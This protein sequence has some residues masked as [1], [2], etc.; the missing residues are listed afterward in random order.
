M[1][2]NVFMIP[3]ALTVRAVM[4]KDRFDEFVKSSEIRVR[5]TIKKDEDIAILINRAGY[6]FEE[7]FGLKKTHFTG[8]FFFW[9]IQKGVWEAVFSKYYAQEEIEK[10]KCRLKEVA[11]DGI[12]EREIGDVHTQSSEIE[13]K[14]LIYPTSF[15]DRSILM[16]T[17]T[18][19][20]IPYN[21]QGE[22]IIILSNE[23]DLEIFKKDNP[24]YE[25]RI[26]SKSN[27]N[28]AYFHLNNIDEEYKKVVQNIT[29]QNVMRSISEIASMSIESEEVLEDD[30][31]LIT[32]VCD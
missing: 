21:I 4:G 20:G 28:T 19:Y 22:N 11:G 26:N 18:S 25:V 31:I 29:Y 10:F 32:V 16:N 7:N 6:D 3:V 23:V 9:E 1:S 14:E 12:F 17:L 30:S 8:G 27:L 5:T 24:Y 2:I 15:V 13:E